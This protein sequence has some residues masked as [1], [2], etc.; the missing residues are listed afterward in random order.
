MEI[1]KSTQRY[2]QTQIGEI[3]EDWRI[4]K[5]SEISTDFISGGTPSTSNPEYW[6][7]NI[8]WMR[9]AWIKE[10]YIKSGEKF[11]TEQGLKNSASN[12]IPKNNVIIATRVSIGNIAI[13]KIDVAINQDLT[14]IVIDKSKTNEEYLYWILLKSK[15]M[16]NSC[17][18]GST[19]M[20]I[21][22]DDLGDLRI[23]FP[24]ISEQQKI[25]SILSK[26]DELIQKT[27]QIIKQTQRLKKGLIQRL[28]TKGIGHSEY[29]T[30]YFYNNKISIPKDW[31]IVE[32]KDCTT[33][34]GSGITPLGGSRVYVKDGIP[35][36]RS[37]NVHFDGLKLD[38]VAYITKDMHDEM[39]RT[40]LHSGDV[41]L[42][43]TGASIGRCTFV[44]RGFGEGNVNQHV[45]IIRPK[46]DLD[47]IFLSIFL[48]SELGQNVIFR[49]FSGLS[50]EGLNFRQ[51]SSF[52]I[53]LPPKEEQKNIGDII[54]LTNHQIMKEYSYKLKTEQ[55]KKG[56]ML[57]LLTGQIRV[58]V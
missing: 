49:S 27:D 23:A 55:L 18:Q 52:Q 9:S 41:L 8:P 38:D 6:N 48:S 12:I 51:I 33:K 3:P 7:G 31:I 45:C 10:R 56:L 22:R 19:I 39:G 37:Q 44:P 34:I 26:V 11:I 50:R 1:Q 4:V 16:I 13:N 42:N 21:T 14:G 40:K 57:K 2:K 36:I 32:L 28:L 54:S 46:N 17:I 24:P 30:V 47:S 5:L 25:A 43:I 58:K 15:D 53:P 29:K 35:L 20:G